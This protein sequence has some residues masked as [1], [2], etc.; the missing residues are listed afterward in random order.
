MAVV[1]CLYICPCMCVSYPWQNGKK[2]IRDLKFGTQTPLDH[3]FFFEKLPRHVDF[4]HISSIALFLI[5][6]NENE[7]FARPHSHWLQ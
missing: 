6:T 4:P 3:I 2:M 5:S 7:D 1:G